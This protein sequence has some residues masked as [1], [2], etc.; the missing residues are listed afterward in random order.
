MITYN[1]TVIIAP[2]QASDIFPLH[3]ECWVLL[4]IEKVAANSG[5]QYL[6]IEMKLNYQRQEHQQLE[7]KENW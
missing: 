2:S 5:F 4:Y 3:I 7:R 1:L 6:S